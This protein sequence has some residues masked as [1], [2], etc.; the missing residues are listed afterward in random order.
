MERFVSVSLINDYIEK[1]SRDVFVIQ[2]ILSYSQ[3]TLISLRKIIRIAFRDSV[4]SSYLTTDRQV[5]PR[6]DSQNKVPT[7]QPI[8]FLFSS[9]L[10]KVE[11]VTR[12]VSPR[13]AC[14]ES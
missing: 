13:G 6:S 9:T 11:P 14:V 1:S 5:A 2:L 4:A 7:S 8:V 3:R 10:R 12:P